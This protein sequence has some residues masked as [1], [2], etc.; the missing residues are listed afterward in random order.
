[1]ILENA[2]ALPNSEAL[3]PLLQDHNA[4][5]VVTTS[6]AMPADGLR[7]EAACLLQRGCAITQV[8]PLSVLHA[9]QRIVHSILKTGHLSPSD[10]DRKILCQ[11]AEKTCGSPDVVDIASALL[12]KC[13]RECDGGDLLEEFTARTKNL[14]SEREP[15]PPSSDPTGNV[16]H[17]GSITDFVSSLIDGS[18]LPSC[19]YF[20]LCI[21]SCFGCAPLPR[22][23]VEIACHLAV[24]AD[25]KCNNQGT[26]PLTYLTS[27]GLLRVHPAAVVIPLGGSKC[28]G[29]GGLEPSFYYV[30]PLV[31]DALRSRMEEHDKAFCVSSA[32]KALEQFSKEPTTDIITA[33]VLG[34]SSILMDG[35]WKHAM[36]DPCYKKIYQLYR[37]YQTIA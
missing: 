5:I 7:Q 29:V 36:D 11:I 4:H 24:G 12:Q 35:P 25:D 3:L 17:T 18:Q 28:T 21:F 8:N 6:L 13:S 20:L 31:C 37:T 33:F 30:P 27:A 26:D 2:K 10:S 14:S 19:S 16:T 1:M 9:T 32:Y 34:L 23:V 15:T 22:A